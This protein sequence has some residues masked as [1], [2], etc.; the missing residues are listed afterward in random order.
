MALWFGFHRHVSLRPE[1]MLNP[2]DPFTTEFTVTNEG[3]AEVRDVKAICLI[4]NVETS[5]HVKGHG[6][7]FPPLNKVIPT[8]KVKSERIKSFVAHPLSRI[9]MRT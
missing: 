9:L 7:Y 2:S 8:L 3:G 1:E 5:N 4:G 6:F